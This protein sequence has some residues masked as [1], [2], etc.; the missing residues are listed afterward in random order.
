M[1]PDFLPRI[2][3]G[4]ETGQNVV[5]GTLQTCQPILRMFVGWGRSKVAMVK[6]GL[7]TRSQF[8]AAGRLILL[9]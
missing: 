7:S 5:T 3:I 6:P 1:F 4:I 8:A 9:N 2:T